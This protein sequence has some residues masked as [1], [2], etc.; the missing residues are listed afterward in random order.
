MKKI[1]LQV[2]FFCL[3]A[4]NAVAQTTVIKG[5]TVVV[6]FQGLPF[7]HSL[8]S[9]AN[10]F[11]QP[12]FTGWGHMGSVRDYFL[13]Q[14]DG[15]VDV[16]SMVI[17]VV[18][19][20]DPDYYY[21]DHM[22]NDIVDIVAAIN[23]AYPAGFQNL[24]VD[25]NNALIHFC[26]LTKNGGGA[27]SFGPQGD[28]LLQ[29]KNNGQNVFVH[30]GNLSNY[31]L[32]QTPEN[33]TICHEMGHNVF[34]WSDYYST[35]WSNL[36]HY[37]TMGGGGI[38]EGSFI[39][40][41]PVCPPLRLKNGWISNIINVGTSTSNQTYTA[42]SN[43]YSTIYKYTNPSNPKEYILIHPQNYSGY[44]REIPGSEVDRGL[45]LYYVD[46]DG[47]MDKA[48][49]EPAGWK[50]RL[51]Q[52]DNIDEMHMEYLHALGRGADVRGDYNDLYDNVK[53]SFPNGT[54][55]RWKDGGEFGLNI[56]NISAPGPSMTF[57][58]VGRPST[59]ITTSDNNGKTSPWGVFSAANGTSRTFT[60]VPN[61]GYEINQVNVN[62]AA[63]TVS[64]NSL[65]LSASGTKRIHVT[66]KRKTT[67]D[68]LPSPWNHSDI[69]TA[70][71]TGVSGHTSG[72][73]FVESY[74]S[75]I[76]NNSD[77]FRFV[78]RTLT[79]NG[80]ITAK[81]TYM[82]KF[83]TW[84][85][86][87]LMIRENLSPG[88]VHSMVVMT[89]QN[90]Y[91]RSQK[92]LSTNGSS[93]DVEKLNRL[94][95]YVLY[96]WFRITRTGN[97]IKSEISYNKVDWV[98]LDQE[99]IP[100]GN[101]V[102]VGMVATGATP[103]GPCKAWFDSVT[104]TSVN[105]PPTVSITSPVNNAT[106]TI[107]ANITINATAADA[108]GTV[109]NV[110]FYNGNTLLGTDA[111]AP[112]TYTWTGVAAGAYSITAR[113]TDN[114]GAI[115]TSTAVSIT[116]TY[117][118]VPPTV[119]I[120]SPVNNTTFTAPASI[121]INATAADANG[122]VSN[123]Q[124]YNGTTLLGSDATSPYSYTWSGVTA[125]TYSITAK[126]TDNLGAATTSSIIYVT[127]TSGG[128]NCV[129]KPIPNATK[130]VVRNNWNDQN[131]GSGVAN[132][133]EALQATH[134][135]WGNSYLWVVESGTPYAVTSG[136]TYIISFD[137]KDNTNV[138]LSSMQVAFASNVGTG[139][140][141]TLKFPAVTV[142]SGYS[143]AAY[144]TK[145]VNIVATSVGTA[146]LSFKLNWA[147]Q[148]NQVV[149]DLFKN[150]SICEVASARLDNALEANEDMI[151][152]NPAKNEVN[153]RLG[154]EEQAQIELM[155]AR[156]TVLSSFKTLA[157]ENI[158]PLEGF[159]A[160]LYL[161]RI[162]E[163]S[164]EKVYRLIKE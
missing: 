143:S 108:D 75:D 85:K 39:A 120:I 84:A 127:V 55:F 124:F 131:S 30:K 89:P 42:V 161:I 135:A 148:P 67:L 61:P 151:Y 47:G 90:V 62:G 132:T 13:V 44:Y 74:G 45:A 28:G 53:N 4:F 60:F 139:G 22:G 126:A 9:V 113:A 117:S 153:V 27:G 8:D 154:L 68:P 66:Y 36:G 73:F 65:T 1:Y 33:N 145:S 107:P 63:T 72:K 115:I 10:M 50:I 81:I 82:N 83:N 106:F 129:N 43:S 152:P 18:L 14:S 147:G 92:R 142:P 150:I 134:R 38:S 159:S 128:G 76:W 19:P 58:V 35:P 88:S 111:T 112:Y 125:G 100:M 122:T 144:T 109:S 121:T 15:K 20:H 118:N 70:S 78:Y 46:E 6:E 71:Q 69:G 31:R 97:S 87:G 104:V 57:T 119:N 23:A 51:I 59:F 40:P 149:V 32:D 77:D 114:A 12:G 21:K 136:K 86:A 110:Q 102:Y 64:N 160:G 146:Y 158:L 96:N 103:D 25:A 91:T 37:C 133:T 95:D 99:T 29:I 3:M 24:S 138:A 52:A 80:S 5:L 93:I 49:L 123:V 105:I 116:I 141:P 98:E 54:P 11:N 162:K 41:M 79:G 2:A 140:D 7:N 163:G 16:S 34:N 130:W 137:Y 94:G 56:I 48:G 26:V 156:G 157:R 155:D 101:Q 17:K 164:Q